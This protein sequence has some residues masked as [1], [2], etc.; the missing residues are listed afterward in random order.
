MNPRLNAVYY[1]APVEDFLSASDD[2]V[3]APL[4]SPHGYTFAPEKPAHIGC[5][6]RPTGPRSPNSRA[7]AL[8]SMLLTSIPLLPA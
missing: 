5:R 8:S 7:T 2:T 1:A 3:Y 6:C 4:T